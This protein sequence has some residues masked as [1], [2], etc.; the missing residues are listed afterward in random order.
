[1]SEIVE[2][3]EVTETTEVPD[4]NE[5]QPVETKDTE[6][7]SK[8]WAEKRIARLAEQKAHA[9]A[10][11]AFMAKQAEELR[12][13][14]AQYEKP[15]QTQEKA[16]DPYELAEKIAEQRMRQAEFARAADSLVEKG[17]AAYA[18][19]EFDGAVRRLQDMGAI[20][21]ENGSPSNVLDAILECDAPHDVLFHLGAHPD[22]AE[23]MVSM[24][25]RALIRAIAK[26]EAKLA[27][28]PP[29]RV[30]QAP[31]PVRP[32]SGGGRTGEPINDADD[33]ATWMKKREKQLAKR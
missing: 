18:H 17:R 1:M 28:T 14:L 10:E 6:S 4:A 12:E 16:V 21:A 33:M 2:P 9:R 30:S 23:R 26:L 22:V 3:I 19:E 15:E 29:T 13:R 31:P 8:D 32:V 25:P 20:F 5:Q 24:S 27:N 7:S 11:A